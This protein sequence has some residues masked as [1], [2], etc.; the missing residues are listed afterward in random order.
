V[1]L[2]KDGEVLFTAKAYNNR[3][4]TEWLAFE[5][6]QA[7]QDIKDDRIPAM[8]VCLSSLARW[9]GLVERAGRYLTT[10]QA[11]SIYDEGMRFCSAH[12]LLATKSFERG[13]L[14]FIIRP[15]L[16]AFGHLCYQMLHFRA[17]VRHE[18]CFLDEDA[19]LWL[20]QTALRAHPSHQRSWVLKASKLRTFFSNQ[21]S[22][23]CS[24]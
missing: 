19:M 20:K 22:A 24:M 9:F 11:Q 12:L 10:A 6:L 2:K 16:H 18:H 8:S 7:T 1:V 17:N 5:L 3:C 23:A 13:K 14:H 15:K 21:N 4:I